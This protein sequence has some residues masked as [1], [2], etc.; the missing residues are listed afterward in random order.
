MKPSL[1]SATDPSQTSISTRTARVRGHRHAPEGSFVN[2]S[3]NVVCF[4]SFLSPGPSVI[5]WLTIIQCRSSASIPTRP[6]GPSGRRRLVQALH[7]QAAHRRQIPATS[8]ERGKDASHRLP[9]STPVMRVND[10]QSATHCPRMHGQHDRRGQSI[11]QLASG[12]RV[13][14]TTVGSFLPGSRLYIP[15]L[16]FVECTSS[17]MTRRRQLCTG[18]LTF[19]AAGAKPDATP[20]ERGA[21]G[22]ARRKKAVSG[23]RNIFPLSDAPR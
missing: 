21:G 8:P 1:I 23:G 2:T 15:N 7:P 16:L 14:R 6:P 9:A 18:S 13:L 19:R 11:S 20:P 4:F 3:Q 22:D 17:D 5:C 10:P 12:F